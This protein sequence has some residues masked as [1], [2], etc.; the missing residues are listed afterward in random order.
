[1]GEFPILQFLL[2][3]EVQKG[4]RRKRDILI[5]EER[6]RKGRLRGQGVTSRQDYNTDLQHWIK[7]F[8]EKNS[9]ILSK[10]NSLESS[11]FSELHSPNI[12]AWT[13]NIKDNSIAQFPDLAR[14]QDED[15]HE[16]LQS[17]SLISF[18]SMVMQISI[19]N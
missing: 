5:E 6:K 18:H 15:F 8:H 2:G 11:L 9:T 19:K 4:Y 7:P 14:G 13:H 1:M 17:G 10:P 12:K 16:E 3:L